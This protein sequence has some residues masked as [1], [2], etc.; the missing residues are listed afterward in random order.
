MRKLM[1]MLGLGIM[2][3]GVFADAQFYEVEIKVTTTQ[4]RSGTAKMIACD[5]RTDTNTLYRKQGK[6]KIK[7]AIWGC[8]CGTLVRGIPFTSTTN[9][10]GYFFWNETTK[11][12]L[13][14]KL[15]WPICNRI[16]LSAKKAEVVWRLASEDGTFFLLGSGFG[17]LKDT[18][19][20]E[21]CT[22]VTSYFSKLDG[23]FAGWMMPDAI[24]TTKGTSEICTWCTKVPGKEEV[25]A[26]ALGWPICSDKMGAVCFACEENLA[27]AAYGTWKIKYNAKAS[28]RL[29]NSTVLTDA[30]TFPSYV[31]EAMKAAEANLAQTK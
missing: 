14:V 1:I 10:F 11:Q 3:G 26:F 15:D 27:S 20:K 31:V 5:L 2:A 18:A 30:Y 29:E 13:A 24:V 7:G 19:T 25:T 17:V 28:K 23:S 9:A 6:V 22:L 16:D 21:P 4:T 12:P 8:D